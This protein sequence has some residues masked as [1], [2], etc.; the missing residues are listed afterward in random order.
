MLLVVVPKREPPVDAAVD[1]EFPNKDVPVEAAVFPNSDFVPVVVPPPK[2]DPVEEA[3][4]PNVLL[5]NMAEL[6]KRCKISK[7]E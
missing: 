4:V 1:V 3:G 6:K 7:Q 5:L 2:T